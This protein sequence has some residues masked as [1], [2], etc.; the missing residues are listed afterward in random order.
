VILFEY[1][2]NERVRA[3]LRL[4]YL[5]DRM[6]FF[7]RPGDARQHQVALT[8]LFDLLDATER[9]DMKGSVLQDLERQKNVLLGLQ[10]HPSVDVNTLKA[11]LLEIERAANH[12]NATGKTGQS[13][14]ENEWLTSLRGRLSVPGGATQVDMPSFHAWQYRSET[15]R[16]ADLLRWMTPL[17]PLQVG[18]AIVLKLLRESGQVKAAMG[19]QGAYQQM[20]SGKTYQLLRVWVDGSENIFPEISAN[21]YMVWIRFAAQDGEL[22]PQP[23]LLDVPF[24]M[25]L[26]AL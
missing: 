16:C 24:N 9:T 14:R 22:K 11:L 8:A 10:D 13:L 6:M 25:A 20:L 26:C 21:K 3:F 4:E 1:P 2:F 5:F 19:P 7:A 12:L 23:V 15:E 17:M 18:I